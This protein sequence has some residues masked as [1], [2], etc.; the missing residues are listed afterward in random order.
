MNLPTW[1]GKSRF[2]YEGSVTKG[3]EIWFGKNKR[4][5]TVSASQYARLLDHFREQEVPVGTSRDKPRHGSL[6]EWLQANVTRTAV[7]SYLAPILITERYASRVGDR[8]RIKF[9]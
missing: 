8:T 6:G 2:K 7:A 1:T 9:N 4:P 5:I 3:T